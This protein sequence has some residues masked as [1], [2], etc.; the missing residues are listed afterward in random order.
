[1]EHPHQ[2]PRS[3]T[4]R[5]REEQARAKY[6]AKQGPF[7]SALAKEYR[8]LCE[9]IVNAYETR[10]N[11][12]LAGLSKPMLKNIGYDKISIKL[13]HL[14]DKA[15]ERLIEHYLKTRQMKITKEDDVFYL[16]LYR[17]H[18]KDDKLLEKS[19]YQVWGTALVKDPKIT[20]IGTK[21]EGEIVA[22][23]SLLGWL[24]EKGIEY[25]EAERQTKKQM[26]DEEQLNQAKQAVMEVDKIFDDAIKQREDGTPIS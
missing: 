4:Q 24:A 6:E 22:Y 15:D 13:T 23:T 17:E 21:A 9:T 8:L 7:H 19:G 11:K 3:R 16:M 26:Y 20:Q 14:W 5:R 10:L 2:P 1:M 25:S 18:F 12:Y